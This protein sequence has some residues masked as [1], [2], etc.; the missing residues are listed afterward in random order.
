MENSAGAILLLVF[1]SNVMTSICSDLRL[2]PQ[3]TGDTD[4]EQGYKDL[5]TFLLVNGA[6]INV[7][8]KDGNT[9]LMLAIRNENTEIATFLIE[10]GADVNAKT[11]SGETV[12][13]VA[14]RNYEDAKFFIENG[15]DINSNDTHGKT[16]LIFEARKGYLEV[17]RLLIEN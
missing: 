8:D 11:D 4:A 15:A 1:L 13:M 2:E 14:A 9:A 10:N 5:A 3:T 17:G 7:G 12:L 6:D 16:A